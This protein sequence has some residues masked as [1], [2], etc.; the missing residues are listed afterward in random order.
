MREWW[1]RQFGPNLPHWVSFWV[2]VAMTVGIIGR[3]IVVPPERGS[4]V[5]IYLAGGER[6]LA[7]E[8]LYSVVPGLDIFRNPPGVAAMFVPL[9]LLEKK[10]AAILWRLASIAL[11]AFGIDQLMKHVLPSVGRWRK[12]GVWVTAAVFMIPAV[13]NGQINLL[14]TATAVCGL[15]ASVRGRWWEAAAWLAGCGYLKLASFAVGL[16]VCVRFPQPLSWRFAVMTAVVAVVPF[17]CQ[18]PGYV[19]DRHVEFIEVMRADDRTVAR[20]DRAPRDWT[21]VARGVVG[22]PVPRVI[23]LAMSLVAAASFAWVV[24]TSRRTMPA[25]VVLPLSLGLL[26][27]TLF[28]PSTEGNTYCVLAPVVGVVLFG[29]PSL[30]RW[31]RVLV[32]AGAIG[33]LAVE[34]RSTGSGAEFDLSWLHPLGAA[35]L[36]WGVVRWACEPGRE[37]LKAKVGSGT[38]GI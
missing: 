24:R 32:W 13:N 18:H 11:Y 36:V 29:L 1:R 9:T 19:L 17:V 4:V 30:D 37:D 25:A 21:V 34:I 31:S 15:T 2:W 26:W 27:F 22:E 20:Y 3:V 14:L 12:C 6:W 5:P 16:L 23:A 28:G 33:L 35:A 10:T 8:P 7:G 38:G